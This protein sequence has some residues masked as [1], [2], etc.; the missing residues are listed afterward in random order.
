MVQLLR[1]DGLC[2]GTVRARVLPDGAI[3]W[4]DAREL[5]GSYQKVCGPFKG[6]GNSTDDV[7]INLGRDYPDPDRFT[8]VLWDVGGV[9]QNFS[10][11]ALLCAEGPITSYEGVAQIELR[12]AADIEGYR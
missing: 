2:S 3:S 8:I 4:Q 1:Q 9:T 10:G 7:F 11:A 5:V 6:M 12:D